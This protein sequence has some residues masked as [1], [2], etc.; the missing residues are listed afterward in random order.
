MVTTSSHGIKK[1][2]VALRA[3]GIRYKLVHTPHGPQ[4]IIGGQP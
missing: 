1:L 3:A 4:I 2:I